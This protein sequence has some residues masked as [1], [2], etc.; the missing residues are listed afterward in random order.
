MHFLAHNQ[1]ILVL[2]VLYI[3]RTDNEINSIDVGTNAKV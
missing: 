3:D 1:N 2:I